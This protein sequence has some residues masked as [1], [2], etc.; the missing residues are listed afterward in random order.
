MVRGCYELRA[1]YLLSCP[2]FLVMSRKPYPGDVS[3]EKLNFLAPYLT[4]P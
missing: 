1:D 4:L 2:K 3:D